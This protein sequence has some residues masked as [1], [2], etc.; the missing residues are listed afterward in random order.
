M[1][2][3]HSLIIVLLLLSACR[4]TH[5]VSRV[6]EA[7]LSSDSTRT[8]VDSF[9]TL[10]DFLSHYALQADSLIVWVQSGSSFSETELQDQPG[11]TLQTGCAPTGKTRVPRNAKVKVCGLRLN[12]ETHSQSNSSALS[13]DSVS[14]L[15]KSASST[16]VKEKEV[17]KSSCLREYVLF[18]IFMILLGIV[19]KKFVWHK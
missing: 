18:F 11:P 10:T 12:A 4:A 8:H 13:A 5:T 17:K 14:S 7:T 6:Q 16:E 1:K 9:C 2:Q 19:I 15:S 3:L